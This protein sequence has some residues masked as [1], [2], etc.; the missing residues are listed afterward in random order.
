MCQVR[1][2]LQEA[3]GNKG[4]RS[5]WPRWSSATRAKA[6]A[7]I[8]YVTATG[9][10]CVRSGL[11]KHTSL[12]T[13]ELSLALGDMDVY[14]KVVFLAQL[15]A[16]VFEEFERLTSGSFHVCSYVGCG[17][18]RYLGHPPS[19]RGG[20]QR[21]KS[22]HKMQR[23]VGD[24][25]RRTSLS[26]STCGCRWKEPRLTCRV[27]CLSQSASRGTKGWRNGSVRHHHHH[28]QNR[29]VFRSHFGSSHGG[30]RISTVA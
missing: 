26:S 6:S 10:A 3:Q 14:R 2:V 25:S 16:T 4:R 8:S 7:M 11:F 19:A 28:H 12:C 17:G 22:S 5:Q 30:H 20:R 13:P 18:I 29:G 15:N 24:G 9:V 1:Q 21:I 23:C 27:R